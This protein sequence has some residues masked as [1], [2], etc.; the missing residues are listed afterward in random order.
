M[1]VFRQ[2]YF[3]KN[4]IS[5]SN[6]LST[7]TNHAMRYHLLEQNR[8][9]SGNEEMLDCLTWRPSRPQY[10]IRVEGPLH[11]AAVYFTI[12]SAENGV[13][14]DRMKDQSTY[15]IAF[16]LHHK[17]AGADADVKDQWGTED[18]ALD[19]GS[20]KTEELELNIGRFQARLLS[21]D[22]IDLLESSFSMGSGGLARILPIF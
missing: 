22:F 9:D 11:C 17:C 13:S 8:S 19:H 7:T 14:R 1:S 20:L 6:I 3:K 15:V 2:F 12:T 16:P 10:G 21:L 18:Q 5:K 4:K